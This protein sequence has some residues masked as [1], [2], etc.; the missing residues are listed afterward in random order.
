MT[1][2]IGSTILHSHQ[3]Y[4]NVL[5]A[6]HPHQYLVWSLFSCRHSLGTQKCSIVVLICISLMTSDVGHLLMYLFA[7]H[8]SSLV[9]CLFKSCALLKYWVV[10]FLLKFLD[11]FIYSGYKFL[12]RYII[13]RNFLPFCGS[14]FL[15]LDGVLW[16]TN[17]L[18]FDEIPFTYFF[19]LWL[20]MALV[21]YRRS[22]CKI[23]NHEGFTP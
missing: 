20:R 21:F 15:F 19:F 6:S 17:M 11:F 10:C 14:S 2:Q 8:L 18:N 7:I 22:H 1:F 12:I 23:Q 16:S 3:Q 5:D 4:M 13:C 9:K